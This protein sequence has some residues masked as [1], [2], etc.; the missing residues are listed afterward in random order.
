MLSFEPDGFFGGCLVVVVLVGLTDAAAAAAAADGEERSVLGA[1]IPNTLGWF[2]SHISKPAVYRE[3]R[4]F[5][6]F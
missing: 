3:G 1:F 4:H 6:V 2:F 5:V